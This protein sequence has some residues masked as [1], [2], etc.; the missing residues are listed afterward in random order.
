[1]RTTEGT[2]TF[3][4]TPTAFTMNQPL[5]VQNQTLS[6]YVSNADG[7]TV[8]FDLAVANK[9]TVTLGGNRTLALSNP[10]TGQVFM[11]RLLQDGTGSRT[12]T[13]FSGI[14]WAGGTTPTLTTTANKADI[15]GFLC[16]GSGAYSGFVIG[17]NI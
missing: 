4:Q 6:G 5:R 14:S 2:S 11:I 7:A 10:Q 3:E 16:T 8:T 17:Q 12:V 15:F 1:M 13:W 9:H